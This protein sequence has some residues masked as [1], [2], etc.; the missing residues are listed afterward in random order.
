MSVKHPLAHKSLIT[1]ED[2]EPY[3]CLSFEQGT[4]NSF[5]YSEEIHSTVLHP[6]N[7]YVS[8]R[9]T[10][11]NLVIGLNGYTIS[12]GILSS[13]LNGTEI[14]AIPL[15]S[16]EQIHVGYIYNRY[17]RLSNLAQKYIQKLKH[18]IELSTKR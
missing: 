5:Y 14:T 12:T 13:D 9:A 3:P 4:I 17:S 15:D 10:L 6:K 2:L 8:D 11:F 1:F 16:D 7:I 18:Y